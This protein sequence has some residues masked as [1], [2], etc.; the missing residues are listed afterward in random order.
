MTI[1]QMT[2]FAMDKIERACDLPAHRPGNETQREA[3]RQVAPTVGAQRERVFEFIQSRGNHG[4]T[5]EEISLALAIRQSAVCARVNEL[6]SGPRGL[7]VRITN[8]NN[9]KRP[10]T[11]GCMAKVWTT[12]A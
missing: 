5:I 8:E 3:A 12:R 11:S 2:M 7:P 9:G 6:W 4:A 10:T 1:H